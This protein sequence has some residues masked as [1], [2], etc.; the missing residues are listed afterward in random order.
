MAVLPFGSRATSPADPDAITRLLIRTGLENEDAFTELYDLVVGAVYG[1][2]LRVLRDPAK[3]EEVTQEVMLETWRLAARY[4]PQR[5]SG[6][7]WIMT[8]AHRR[9][10][11]RV[12][13]AQASTDRDIKVGIASHVP[14][15]DVVSAEVET[16][17][18]HAQVR[19]ALTELTHTQ[20]QALELAYYKGYTHVEVA[21]ALEIPLG[22]AKTRLRDGLIHLRDAMEV[23]A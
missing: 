18:E 13:S 5:G 3:S 6:K 4:D 10:I 15:S 1:L 16:R 17:I 8:M 9:A 21:A 14:D 7:T 20:R 2:V 11:D 12:R 22:T 23:D 19:R